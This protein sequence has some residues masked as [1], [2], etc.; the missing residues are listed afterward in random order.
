MSNTETTRRE[1][2]RHG[3][4]RIT[5]GSVLLLEL[6]HVVSDVATEDVVLLGLNLVLLILALSKPLS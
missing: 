3:I 2:N 4:T 6:G 5:G 1:L